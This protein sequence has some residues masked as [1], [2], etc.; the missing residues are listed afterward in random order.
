MILHP[1]VSIGVTVNVARSAEEAALQ[2]QRGGMVTGAQL[3][4][5]EEAAAAAEAEAEAQEEA[6]GESA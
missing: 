6:E 3:A 5:E 1:E 2:A 4:A